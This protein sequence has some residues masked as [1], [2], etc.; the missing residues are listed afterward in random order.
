MKQQLS[1]AILILCLITA[2]AALA[3]DGVTIGSGSVE[4][5]AG[6]A[7][8][9]LTVSGPEG[10]E[11]RQH[12]AAGSVAS[13]SLYDEAG[14]VLA[15][16]A[17]TWQLTSLKA[18][19][20]AERSAYAGK[21]ESTS[22]TF[23]IA[24][25]SVANPNAVEG[26]LNKD[27]V[28]LDD[29]IVD[30]S[31][32]IGLDCA[33]GESFGFDTLRLKENNLRIKFEDTSTTASFPGNDWQ[34]LVNEKDN[35]SLDKF[36]I[37]DITGSKTPFTIEAGAGNH[38]LYVDDGG[39]LGLGTNSPAVDAHIISG[40]TPTLRLDQDGSS[41]FASQTW[42]LAGNEANFFVRDVTNGSKLPFKIK[43]GAPDNTLY[44]EDTG[45]VGVGAGTNPA[46]PLHV[47]RTTTDGKDMLIV[48]NAGPARILLD[49]TASTATEWRINHANDGVLRFVENS[50]AGAANEFAL[51]SGGDLTISGTLVTSGTTC[52]G[53]CDLVFAPGYDLETIEEHAAA[54]W[55]NS[56]L[57]GVGPTVEN[58]PI[59]LSEKTGGMLNELEKAHI[60][61]A[62]LN[63]GLKSKDAEIDDLT[64]RL[65]R[66]EALMAVPAE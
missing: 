48:E 19:V 42:D 46:G 64:E 16:G 30:G 15:D 14:S 52:S 55:S 13:M 17:Y 1:T 2:P 54:M 47:K 53:G 8:A 44:L 49:N 58:A 12:I 3:A 66:L 51:T 34:I 45:D 23:T 7:A 59:N 40:N 21:G 4:F 32:C 61:I 33:N 57:P 5:A 38:S 25:G 27:Q 26:S 10:F 65:A 56:Y 9:L 22:G 63:E 20:P 24:G 41:G 11:H 62:Q 43:P 60:Y 18:E 29:L 31:A 37:E 28:F 39:R 36:S 6:D 50:D 35:G